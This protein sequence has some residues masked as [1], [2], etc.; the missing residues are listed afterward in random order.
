MLGEP[1]AAVGRN[2][3]A[4]G[5]GIAVHLL[6]DLT[7]PNATDMPNAYWAVLVAV[8]SRGGLSSP[9]ERCETRCFWGET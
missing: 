8:L 6:L 2:S 3:T 4:P 1:A 9:A 7:Q 5:A